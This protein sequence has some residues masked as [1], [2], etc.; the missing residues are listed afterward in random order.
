MKFVGY[1]A[2]Y[3]IF[4][5]I[6]SEMRGMLKNKSDINHN[7]DN[8][9]SLLTHNHD[10]SYASKS[11]THSAAT[12]SA[13][14]FMS[15][16]DKT[17]LDGIASNANNYSH[18]SSHA[19]SII[20][21]DASHRFVSDTEKNTWNS[22]LNT[23]VTQ[24]TTITESGKYALDAIEKNSSI[25]GTLANQISNIDSSLSKLGRES[26]RNTLCVVALQG[27]TTKDVTLSEP[28][29]NYRNL[30]FVLYTNTVF[31][32]ST[33][34]DKNYFVSGYVQ[35]TH[36]Y[37]TSH[38]YYVDASYLSGQKVRLQAVYPSSATLGLL[39]IG[40]N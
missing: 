35:R 19:A 8:K 12:Q 10:S 20:T 11:H 23:S 21:Q 31:L 30:L 36:W 16:A 33:T 6:I 1:N 15:S 9:Y 34:M 37:D 2:L 17:K 24:S 28:V 27:G 32:A 22:K 5:V 26:A 13:S 3:K 40:F 25:E 14:G 18:P 39:I 7:H 4:T 38:L 29:T